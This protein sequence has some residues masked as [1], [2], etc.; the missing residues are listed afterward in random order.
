MKSICTGGLFAV[1]MAT[2]GGAASAQGPCQQQ[3]QDLQR[4]V[5]MS[6]R[7]DEQAKQ[8][9]QQML[10]AAAQSPDQSC[11]AVLSQAQTQFAQAESQGAAAESR[12]AVGQ[13]RREGAEQAAQLERE[14]RLS[15]QRTVDERE[16]TG[17]AIAEQDR[18]NLDRAA[19]RDLVGANVRTRDGDDVGEVSAIARSRA[20]NEV[21]AIVDVGGFLGFGERRVPIPMAQTQV[22]AEGDLVTQMTRDELEAIGEYDEDQYITD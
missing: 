12:Q 5:Q 8:R 20:T 14:D 18:S 6:Q 10:T 3:V 2:Y 15:Q 21:F 16:R 13:Q 9:I 4:Q 11:Q 19:A 7:A 17:A 22:N 1:M